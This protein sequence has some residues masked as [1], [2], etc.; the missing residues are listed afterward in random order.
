[1]GNAL[2]PMLTFDYLR[3]FHNYKAIN[4]ETGH[5]N[6]TITNHSW[7]YRYDYS[8]TYSGGMQ[9]GDISN[10]QFNGKIYDS[11]NPNKSGWTMAGVEQDFGVGQW[12]L[13]V[14]SS[15]AL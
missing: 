5:R 3:A 7:S 8:E 6:P 4:P 13:S 9:I 2:S 12:K 14:S 1:M 15:C 10:I 11:T